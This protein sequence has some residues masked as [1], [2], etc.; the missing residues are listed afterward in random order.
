ML[1]TPHSRKGYNPQEEYEPQ[2]NLLYAFAVKN[3]MPACYRI[4][5]GNIRSYC[6]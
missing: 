6:F 1:T 2:I 5:P 3:K 4:L